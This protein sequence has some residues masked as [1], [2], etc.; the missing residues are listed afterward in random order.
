MPLS[1][2]PAP[3]ETASGGASLTS[4][5]ELLIWSLPA[6]VW[7][8]EHVSFKMDVKNKKYSGSEMRGLEKR[9]AE[10]HSNESGL[11][12]FLVG[13]LFKMDTMHFFWF[14]G[15]LSLTSLK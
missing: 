15:T 3:G 9:A 1:S 8:R 10:G 13:D 4:S 12:D 14:T 11:V 6:A 5:A 7:R 2:A